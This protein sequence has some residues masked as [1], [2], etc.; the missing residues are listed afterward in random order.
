MATWVVDNAGDL[1]HLEKQIG[2]IWIEL[3]RRANE[4]S[5]ADSET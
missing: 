5:P 1:A 3:E 4:P 2:D